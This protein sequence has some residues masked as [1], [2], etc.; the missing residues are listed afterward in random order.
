MMRTRTAT[1]EKKQVE[2][3]PDIGEEGDGVA[4]RSVEDLQRLRK[5]ASSSASKVQGMVKKR[6]AK[7]ETRRQVASGLHEAAE[8]AE[9][10]HQR[11]SLEEF[12]RRLEEKAPDVIERKMARSDIDALRRSGWPESL[13]VESDYAGVSVENGMP[14]VDNMIDI[15]D[16]V[17][18]RLKTDE[19]DRGFKAVL[20]V[21]FALSIACR[22]LDA[23]RK[24]PTV[25]HVSTAL[26]PR[27]TIVG[28][29]HGQFKDL[30]HIFSHNGLPSFD[31]PYVFNG[32]F[33]DRGPHSV[34]VLVLIMGF[35]LADPYSIYVN[36]GNH[37][38]FAV[39][40]LYGLVAELE[41]KYGD[42]RLRQVLEA[43]FSYLP[44]AHVVD[45]NVF[46]VHG[47]L[48]DKL[49]TLDDLKAIDRGL[50]PSLSTPHIKMSGT[51]QQQQQ[52]RLKKRGV[53][54]KAPSKHEILKD[55]LWS[56]PSDRGDPLDLECVP[57]DHRGQGVLWPAGLTKLWLVK[58]DF[59]VMIRS[60]Q[61]KDDGFEICHGGKCLT[62]FSASNY[63]G[64]SDNDGAI[65]VLSRSDARILTYRTVSV[66][67][68][69]QSVARLEREGLDRV[70]NALLDHRQELITAFKK[71]DPLS[72]GIIHCDAWAKVMNDVVEMK[73]PWT[74]LAHKFVK[75]LD[76]GTVCY[77][78][79]LR[80]LEHAFH[81]EESLNKEALT[82]HESLY[83]RRHQLTL[84]FHFLDT[85]SNGV[86]DRAALERGCA[87]LNRMNGDDPFHAADVNK[88]LKEL[89][90]DGDGT[91]SFAEFAERLTRRP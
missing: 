12:M 82:L 58:H 31:N 14:T 51:K 2:W 45:H 34:E 60:H 50:H 47:G 22:F 74:H 88:F 41:A 10:R 64:D 79:L 17:L 67:P 75:P 15:M 44:I 62:L 8:Y 7:L 18:E 37:E 32:D 13:S 35:A 39:G 1:V 77:T 23:L 29:I 3:T 28:D 69:A 24:L 56:D 63:Y 25:V 6:Q 86:L 80:R 49:G 54:K 68:V 40:M 30:I 71:L 55:L 52:Q 81:H 61:C 5:A 33:V 85:D 21:K 46:V 76:D 83:R 43:C 72:R 16:M 27:L 89:D 36:R 73:L 11:R 59:G 65:V 4:S 53:K 78:P 19:E 42:P 70:E 84:L 87:L 38:D 26:T 90:L 9:E 48:T 91:I 57:N 20:H 66:A